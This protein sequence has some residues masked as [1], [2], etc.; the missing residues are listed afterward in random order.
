MNK[1]QA[2]LPE[3]VSRSVVRRGRQG[4]CNMSK[5]RWRGAYDLFS[6]SSV[7]ASLAARVTR[8]MEG[9][10]GEK[11]RKENGEY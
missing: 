9:G 4:R 5:A 11:R 3:C 2:R 6:L 1:F 10:K 7:V 8:D